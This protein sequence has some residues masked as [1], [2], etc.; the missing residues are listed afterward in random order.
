MINRGNIYWIGGSPCSG[1]STIAEL[2]CKEFGFDYYKCDDHLDRYMKI[3]VDNNIEIMKKFKYMSMDEI[4]IER[5]VKEQFEDALEFYKASFDVI[6]K[7]INENYVDNN[8]I[9][10]GAAITPEFILQNT[11]N[12]RN[13]M[14]IVPTKEFQQENYAKRSWV[15][16]YLK[17]CSNPQLAFENWM[18]R[19]ILFSQNVLEKAKEHKMN[20]IVVDGS[21]SITENYEYLVDKLEIRK[22]ISI[23]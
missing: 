17:P 13:Y 20:F 18:Q 23:R 19:D 12:I 1:K 15:N 4:W 16:N 21:K 2:L 9:V 5:G 22:N 11:I 10:E 6:V 7:D 3:G 8:L 14:C